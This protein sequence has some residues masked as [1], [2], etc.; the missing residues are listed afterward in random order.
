MGHQICVGIENGK[1]PCVELV[2]VSQNLDL[3]VL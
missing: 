1:V 2:M 3:D